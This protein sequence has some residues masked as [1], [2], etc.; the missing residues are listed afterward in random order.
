VL[1]LSG[2]VRVGEIGRVVRV[3]ELP[4]ELLE[5]GDFLTRRFETARELVAF[6]LLF[7]DFTRRLLKFRVEFGFLGN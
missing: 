1:E 5:V 3:R 7:V 2:V 4:D 6:V